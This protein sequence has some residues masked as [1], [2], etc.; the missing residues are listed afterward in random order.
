MVEEAHKL[1]L[2]LHAW[3][4]PLRG[5]TESEMSEI[6]DKYQIKKWYN[7]PL[8]NGYYTVVVGGRVYLNPAYSEVRTFISQG[9]AEILDNYQ[10][11]GIHIDDYFYPTSDWDFDRPAFEEIIMSE[12]GQA[13]ISDTPSNINDWR[14][15]NINK[16]VKEM[17]TTI[18]SKNSQVIFGISPQGNISENYSGQY[19]DVEKWLKGGYCDWL[20]P[21]LYY[22]F[23]N[24]SCP[25]TQTLEK[26]VALERSSDVK[27]SVGICT[28]KVGE[29]DIYAGSG[30]GEWIE[31]PNIPQQQ[32]D[33]INSQ[34]LDSVSG[35]GVYS[36]SY[37]LGRVTLLINN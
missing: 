34:F 30:A 21:Q 17:Y 16:L 28:Y 14:R 6:S 35:I 18:K 7:D 32:V 31:N 24:E 10:V 2:S 13:E 11:D 9:V 27:L 19:A 37:S 8:K 20:I 33:L 26:W 15:E 12:M 23:K 36:Y 3:L 5:M 25:F 4:N 22:G 1:G 29:N